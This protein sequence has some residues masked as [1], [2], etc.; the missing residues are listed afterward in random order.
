MKKLLL[1]MALALIVAACA[2]AGDDT[3]ASLEDSTAATLDPEASSADSEDVL[4]EFA[5][6]MRDNGISEFP[7]P[8]VDADGNI[9]PFGD[10]RGPGDLG[11]D[12]DTIQ[13]AQAEC[14]PIVEDLALNFLR[15]NRDQLED[16]LYE[17]AACMR[18]EGID[19]ADPDFSQGLGAGGGPFGDIDI[20]DPDFQEAADTCSEVFGAGGF[21][22]PGGRGQRDDGNG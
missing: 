12:R 3:V 18:E 22:F 13:A 19:M 17:F 16:Q 21:G 20:E 15:G 11:V 8:T 6:C 5:Q 10:G 2:D 9:R 4:L 14:V 1:L 7:D